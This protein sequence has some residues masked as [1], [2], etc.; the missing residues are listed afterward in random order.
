MGEDALIVLENAMNP[1]RIVEK[2]PGRELSTKLCFNYDE[3]C[4]AR[5]RVP[6]VP[7]L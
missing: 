7:T 2:V 5:L 6:S 4:E 3:K 1:I